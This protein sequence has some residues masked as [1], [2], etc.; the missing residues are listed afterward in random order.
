MRRV[1]QNLLLLQPVCP[2]ML[3]LCN[4]GR[5]MARL[6]MPGSVLNLR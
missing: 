4:A 5:A 3:L 1:R 2:H 6:K